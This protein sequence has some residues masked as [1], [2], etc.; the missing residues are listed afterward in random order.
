MVEETTNQKVTK[1]EKVTIDYGKRLENG[2]KLIAKLYPDRT[3]IKKDIDKKFDG[4]PEKWARYILD[5]VIEQEGKKTIEEIYKELDKESYEVMKD[6]PSK[7]TTELTKLAKDLIDDQL[8][9][10]SEAVRLLEM[11]DKTQIPIIRHKLELQIKIYETLAEENAI[12]LVK[13]F[14]W[15]FERQVKLYWDK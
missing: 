2:W 6:L 9:E 11:G 7:P 13:E 5:M 3:G 1:P 12:K 10:I 15:E 4:D 8:K 14:K